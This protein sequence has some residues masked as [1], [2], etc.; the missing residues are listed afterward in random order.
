[1]IRIDG[2]R[3]C[4]WCY[5]DAAWQAVTANGDRDL[6]QRHYDDLGRERRAESL[7]GLSGEALAI[8]RDFHGW[9]A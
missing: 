5:S 8:V 1:M 7:R 9:T 2:T 4:E 6:C 3:E